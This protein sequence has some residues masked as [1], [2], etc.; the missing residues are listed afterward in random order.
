M[1]GDECVQLIDDTLENIQNLR[2]SKG[3]EYANSDDQLANFKRLAGRIALTPEAVLLVYLTKH[4]D[5]I[6]HFVKDIAKHNGAPA[7]LSEPIEGRIDDAIN[8]LI[9]LK[10]L[11]RDRAIERRN[12]AIADSRKSDATR[13]KVPNIAVGGVAIG[14]PLDQGRP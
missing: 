8:Y 3:R 9:L 7:N 6:D 5:S 13:E 4:L 2:R 11:L 14:R 1:T 10:G 12:A